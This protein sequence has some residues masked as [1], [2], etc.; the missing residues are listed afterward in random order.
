MPTYLAYWMLVWMSV[1]APTNQKP[2]IVHEACESATLCDGL[3]ADDNG[4]MTAQS[5]TWIEPPQYVP[6]V[7]RD[8]KC[9]QGRWYYADSSWT[10]ADKSRVLL[11]A[12]DG[13]KH[14]I[15]FNQGGK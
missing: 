1:N 7:H 12:E 4:N 11:T 3:V 14:C 8:V 6:A 2:Q 5:I 9:T 13:T 15:L 10:C